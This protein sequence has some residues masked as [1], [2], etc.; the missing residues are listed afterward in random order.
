MRSPFLSLFKDFINRFGNYT[1]GDAGATAAGYVLTSGQQ[2]QVSYFGTFL[3]FFHFP[4][5]RDCDR[6]ALQSKKLN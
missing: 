4:E 5:I 3:W 1:P 2:G 6:F